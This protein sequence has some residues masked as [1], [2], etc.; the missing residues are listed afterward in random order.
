MRNDRDLNRLSLK[1]RKFDK[2]SSFMIRR[3]YENVLEVSKKHENERNI[4][5]TKKG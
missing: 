3:R 1:R 2:K 4:R 5:I